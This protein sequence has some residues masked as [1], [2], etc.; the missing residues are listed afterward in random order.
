MMVVTTG[1]RGLFTIL[2]WFMA[3]ATFA[4]IL[5]AH[6]SLIIEPA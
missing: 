6:P 2:P 4:K 3:W 1:F 5:L